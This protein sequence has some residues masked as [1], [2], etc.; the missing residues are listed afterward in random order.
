MGN[1][2]NREWEKDINFSNGKCSIVT[3]SSDLTQPST[4]G[5][6]E[7]DLL[8]LLFCWPGWNR[9]LSELYWVYCWYWGRGRLG[10]VQKYH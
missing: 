5:S 1:G 4:G 6:S 8:R 3:V 7:A 10:K 2:R 9:L